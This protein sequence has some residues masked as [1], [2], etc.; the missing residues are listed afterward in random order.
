MDTMTTIDRASATRALVAATTAAALAPSVHNTQ[1]WRWRID[2]AVADLYADTR[3]QLRIADPDGRLL[4]LSCGAVLNEACVALAA[5]GV[6]IDVVRIPD[7]DDGDH[8]TILTGGGSDHLARITVTGRVPVTEAT[9]RLYKTAEIRRAD[10]RPLLDEALS[11]A[12]ITALRVTAATFGIGLHQLTRDQAIELASATSRSQ[13]DEVKDLAAHAELDA[14][15]D[16]RRPAGAGVPNATIPD[17]DVPTT[18]PMRDFGHV[19]S[20]NIPAG[21]DNAA[22]YVILYGL[23]EQPRSW[24]RAGEALDAIWLTA[25]EHM[26]ALLPLSAAVESPATRQQLHRILS[27]LGY[28][29]VALRL[30]IADPNLP[31][32]ARTPRL[33]AEANIEVLP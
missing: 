32:L 7:P 33:P 22:T 29:Y 18:V 23:A 20:L 17:R 31:T 30:G 5:A 13:H 15:T 10:R 25:T 14:W 27:G 11:A 16:P 12:A 8:T 6:A 21:H 24:L 2:G 28:P 19:G 26:I 3:R 9:L 1:P 4:T